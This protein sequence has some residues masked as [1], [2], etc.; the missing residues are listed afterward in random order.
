MS[1]L[2][3]KKIIRKNCGKW[4]RL[5]GDSSISCREQFLSGGFLLRCCSLKDNVSIH[6]DSEH[7][8]R[9]LFFSDTHLRNAISRSYFPFLQWKG[10]DLILQNL[11]E[12]IDLTKP[13]ALLFGGDL[14]GESCAFPEG[15]RMLQELP[16]TQKFAIYGN[17]DKKENI[18]IPHK[19]RRKM[20]EKA[21]IQLL[22]N[23]HRDLSPKI[24]LYGM[25]DT[26]MGFPFCSFLKKR[27]EKY[28][29]IAA[30][31]PD[32]IPGRIPEEYSGEKDLFLCGHTHG[33]QIILPGFGAFCTSTFSWKNLERNWYI[34]K[35]SH[36]KMFITSGIGTTFIHTRLFC[37][38][39]IV[40][41]EFRT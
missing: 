34:H 33:G 13:H 23:S 37:P 32:T 28:R 19:E 24:T 21:N 7:I 39:E 4:K 41:L 6:K 27:E 10:S 25:D 40:L 22:V 20:L 15:I 5:S 8:F 14:A 30:H 31:N 26:R 2:L 16:V 1:T 17:W 12:S 9:L 3:Q 11:Q 18:A 35:E 29:V 38:P 36:A